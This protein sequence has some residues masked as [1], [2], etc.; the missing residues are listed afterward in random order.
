MHWIRTED[1]EQGM[2]DLSLRLERE[3]GAGRRIL[4]L[5]SGGSNIT[6]SARVLKA[7]PDQL[8]SL[9]TIS[10]IDERYG[11]PGHDNSNWEQLQRN[12]LALKR[13]RTLP[14]LQAGLDFARTRDHYES[15]MSSALAEADCVIGQL[16]IGDDGHVAGILPHSPPAGVDPGVSDKL[17][18]AYHTPQY[19]RLTLTFAGLQQ[20][21][22]AYVF[23]FGPAKQP[24]LSRLQQEGIPLTEQPA[25]ILKQLPEVYIYNDLVGGTE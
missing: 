19:D 2:A 22:A 11:P 23:V 8:T 1:W 16:G 12:G 18:A 15:L 14:V 20:L 7:L 24:A 4:W 21:T 9:L 5:L 6:I 3:L 13:A 17:I 10:L 25:Q